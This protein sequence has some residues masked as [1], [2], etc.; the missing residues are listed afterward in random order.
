MRRVWKLADQSSLP[1]GKQQGIFPGGK[2]PHRETRMD[3]GDA[4]TLREF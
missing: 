3:T 2:I 4:E 1:E